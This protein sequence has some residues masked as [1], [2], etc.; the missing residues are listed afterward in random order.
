MYD[1]SLNK[2]YY[3]CANHKNMINESYIYIYIYVSNVGMHFPSL[4]DN[5]ICCDFITL[6]FF[7]RSIHCNYIHYQLEQN[8]KNKKI[9]IRES[10]DGSFLKNWKQLRF[11]ITITQIV[12]SN[13]SSQQKFAET[14]L[15]YEY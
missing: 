2:S 5:K 9:A 10:P 8:F 15:F 12:S 7:I 4:G 1:N 3:T 13:L 14:Y 11:K 6:I